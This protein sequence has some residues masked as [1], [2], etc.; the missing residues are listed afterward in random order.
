MIR[1]GRGETRQSPFEVTVSW[2][3]AVLAAM[4]GYIGIIASLNL[5]STNRDIGAVV[6]AATYVTV[7][8]VGPILVGIY[9]TWRRGWS[10]GRAFRIA[11]SLSVAI[12]VLFSPILFVML[13]M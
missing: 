2:V 12:D 11:A 4:G 3:L 5:V 7:A 10:G 9:L 13:S 1:G 8:I 6:G